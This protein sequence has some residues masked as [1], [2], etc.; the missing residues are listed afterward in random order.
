M[1]EKLVI[2]ISAADETRPSWAIV[3]AHGVVRQSAMHD[4]TEGL[5]HIAD[6][7]QV[8]VIVPAI[9]VLLTVVRL[10]KMNRTR[11]LQA[12]PFALE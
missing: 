4:S 9:D 3:D 8:I 5:T 2:D 6:L 7:K 11:L 1:Q 10:P 12:I